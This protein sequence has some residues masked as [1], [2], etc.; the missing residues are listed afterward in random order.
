MRPNWRPDTVSCAACS[1]IV[2]VWDVLTPRGKMMMRFLVGGL[3]FVT[4]VTFV[5]SVSATPSGSVE[6][7]MET[8]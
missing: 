6:V 8:S 2:V 4:T 7:S 1:Q 5:G 3:T